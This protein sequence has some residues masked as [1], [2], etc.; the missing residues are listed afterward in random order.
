V[1]RHSLVCF[2]VQPGGVLFP[3]RRR[4]EAWL[5]F[6][7][8]ARLSRS[9]IGVI[10]GA[11][12]ILRLKPPFESFGGGGMVTTCQKLSPV[13]FDSSNNTTGE[14][15]S[16]GLSQTRRPLSPRTHL[17]GHTN[18]RSW[19]PPH[20]FFALLS[21]ASPHQH[22]PPGAGLPETGSPLAN[23]AQDSTL[24]LRDFAAFKLGVEVE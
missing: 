4:H 23:A 2:S 9:D 3:S 7:R 24:W 12:R 13:T 15:A 17:R 5:V 8:E 22:P 18:P 11:S 14:L 19:P 16:R 10:G 6:F 20:S 1:F 21:D